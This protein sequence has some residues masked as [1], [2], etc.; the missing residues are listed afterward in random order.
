MKKILVT[1]AVSLMT[2]YVMKSACF[3]VVQVSHI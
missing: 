2:N 1:V 3:M